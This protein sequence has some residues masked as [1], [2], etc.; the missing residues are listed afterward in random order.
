MNLDIGAK[1][2]QLR[3][4]RGMTQEQLAAPLGLSAQAIS[5]WESATTMPDIQLLPELSVL[6]GVSIDALFSMTDEK[7]MERIDNM[8]YDIRFL[9]DREFEN[10][11][12]Y[13]KEKVEQPQT[14]ARATLLLARLYNKRGQEFHDLAAPI[15]RQALLLNPE[16]KDAHNAIFDAERC[17]Y[18]D[19]NASNHWELVSFYQDF[20]K[21]YPLDR[22]NYLWLMDLLLADGR[23]KE[24][25]DILEGMGKLERTYHYDLYDGLIARE[26]GD[27]P[28]ALSCWNRM[29]ENYPNLWLAHACRADSLAKLARYDEAMEGYRKAL[30]LQ[31]SPRYCDIPE[32]MAQIA[33]IQKDYATAISMRELCVKT[34]RE[35]WAIDEGETL[36]FHMRQI[37]RLRGL[38]SV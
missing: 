1:I 33:E 13:L 31:P 18:P 25:R 27:I 29:I 30:A 20:V 34:C 11:E 26:E 24:A 17:V 32:A 19:W 16:E 37:W 36:D 15:A 21:K 4:A 5:K 23:A 3:L 22:P 12:Q 7:R 10:T 14:K 8:L 9:S 38:A 6:L 2:R 28:R 35:E